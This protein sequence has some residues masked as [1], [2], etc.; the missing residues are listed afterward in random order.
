MGVKWPNPSSEGLRRY[1]P[2]GQYTSAAAVV[3]ACT[4]ATEC[5]DPCDG[6]C[7]CEACTEHFL[8]SH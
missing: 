6:E 5:A 7:G 2:D 4:C 3:I 1:P 8:D